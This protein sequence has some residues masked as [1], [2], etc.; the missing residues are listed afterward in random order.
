M[1]IAV[2]S[3]LHLTTME[4]NP[5]RYKALKEIFRMCG[6][7]EVQLLI[8]AGDL[9]DKKMANYS[10]FDRIYGES[11]LPGLKTIIIPGN[12]DLTLQSANLIGDGL[13]VFS[14][15]V[16]ESL[17]NS[18]KILFLP[19]KVEQTMGEAI[20]PFRNQLK[21]ER[22]ILIAHGDW[23]GSHNSSD[24][25]EKGTYMPLTRTDIALYN[26]EMA[27]LGHIHLPQNKDVVYY[28]G[29]PCP[30]DISETG[31]R[32][33][34]IFDSNKGEIESH[35]VNSQL[36]YYDERF[37]MLPVENDLELLINDV[38]NRIDNWNIAPSR[39]KYV[40]VRVKI[41]GTS[42]S[43]RSKVLQAVKNAL[44]SFRLY[45]DQEPDL[46]ELSHNP[47]PDRADISEK[48][49]TW[50]DELDWDEIPSNPKKDQI[51]EEALKI[52]YGAD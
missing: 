47:D 19:Y 45:L 10:D 7:L 27:I 20:A 4:K 11:K 16:L 12:H 26:P 29:S 17:N 25:Y 8:I 37:V 32:R 51:L 28:P 9:F 6:K 2:T 33:I 39:E 35:Q 31:P 49:K 48:L 41:T 46:Q 14:E 44:S 15:P 43:D 38:N 42:Q 18:R 52:I 5:E 24:P 22:W 23:T 1:K 34:L 50:I 21:D 40:Q 30:L 36:E 13:V 3:D